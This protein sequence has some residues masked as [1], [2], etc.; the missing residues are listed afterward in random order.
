[1]RPL[2]AARG[3]VVAAACVFALSM[4]VTARTARAQQ[5]NDPRT[6]SLV[7]LAIARR[8]AQLADT[9]LVSYRA[10]AH[11]YL[12]FLAQMG[13]GY[14]DPPKVI[15]TDEL[16]V[17]VYW[18]AP[19]QS[20]Q[21]IVGRRDTLLLPTDISYHRDHL[22]IIQN[23]F[24][25]I[26]RLGDGDEVRDVPHPL[27][28]AG[29]AA[30]EF[31]I[32][33]SLTMRTNQRSYEVIEV[34]VRPVN[35]RLAR[36]VGA[37]YLDRSNGVVVRMAFSFTREA[38]KDP[39][40]EDVSVILE[41]GLVD[42]QFWLPRRQEIEIRRTGSW[43]DFPVRGVIRGRW[44]ICCV[45]VNDST[46][47]AT[48]RG[49]EIVQSPPAE[50][51]AYKFPDGILTHLPADV[52]LAE[53]DDVRRVQDEARELVRAQS[54]E[55]TQR[56][57][58]SA[59]SVSDVLRM[60]RVEGIAVGSGLTR[61][62][63]KGVFATVRGRYGFSDY[64]VKHNVTLGVQQPSGAGISLSAY[65]D[66]RDAGE[67]PE[68]SGVRNS[69]AAQ[70]FGSDLTDL[71]RVRGFALA[72][73]L[74]WAFGQRWR[75]TVAR[76]RE[77]GLAVHATPATGK[78]TMPVLVRQLD[79]G[80]ITLDVTRASGP[81]WFG[82]TFRRTLSLT[83]KQVSPL[84]VASRPTF[85]MGRA[86]LIM[87]A[88]RAFGDDRL[89][90]HTTA[91]AVSGGVTP[92]QSQLYLGGP[93][94][95]PGFDFHSLV[96]NAG[97]SQRVEWRHRV[98]SFPMSLGRFG[99]SRTSVSLAPYVQGIWIDRTTGGSV[100]AGGFYPAVGV[101]AISFFDLFRVDVARGLRGG[102]WTFGLDIARDIWG[103]L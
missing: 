41:N 86:S 44:E 10:T 28:A 58:P 92:I 35:D 85:W 94:T 1:M 49:E 100:K 31:A 61:S 12:T 78:F 69:I 93:V 77:T 8:A 65:D 42:G 50:L 30:Y 7:D 75:L 13:E 97:V 39:Q 34:K 87:N 96:T 67:E 43:M 26:I 2:F 81:G 66:Y 11:G 76:E 33:D 98:A 47:V 18:R 38:L 40:L 73:D 23:N 103:I 88:E 70:E 101:G 5:W 9:G 22:A 4:P 27:S 84:P 90:L 56:T 59:R 14:E 99:S 25:G 29:R 32:T 54:L 37:L 57:V 17:E 51:K 89:V 19:N 64:A 62:F 60:N 46:P 79:A 74:G 48:F 24:P 20:K 45:E 53:N 71:Y 55:R 21:R 72:A 52:K 6:L 91:A 3:G 36:A 68:V 95:G 80:R 15:R 82:M 102:R 83:A 16:A 63:G